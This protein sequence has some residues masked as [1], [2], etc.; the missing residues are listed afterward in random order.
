MNSRQRFFS[1]ICPSVLLAVCMLIGAVACA[2]QGSTGDATSGNATQ[3][4]TA[5]GEIAT[6]GGSTETEPEQITTGE[7][8]SGGG[9]GGNHETFG[10]YVE[11]T[12]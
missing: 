11:F 9:A 4:A 5:T 12:R 3:S 2:G 10:K 7:E 1:R 8:T 6:T